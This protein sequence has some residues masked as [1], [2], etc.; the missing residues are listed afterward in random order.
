M[1]LRHE[2]V[3]S[4]EKQNFVSSDERARTYVYRTAGSGRSN[5]KRDRVHGFLS[6]VSTIRHLTL[7]SSDIP[8]SGPRIY[9][10][11]RGEDSQARREGEGGGPRCR[12]AGLQLTLHS[13]LGSSVAPKYRRKK[14]HSIMTFCPSAL[15]R[16][17]NFNLCN[18]NCTKLNNIAYKMQILHLL[19][20][21]NSD[22][23]S[24]SIVPRVSVSHSVQ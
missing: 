4:V 19:L 18:L 9:R 8:H 2:A 6:T 22:L 7:R 13:Q 5:A 15:P 20:H 16:C 1:E 17:T 21:N 12:A 3:I 14:L 23:Y 24:V 10:N 11:R